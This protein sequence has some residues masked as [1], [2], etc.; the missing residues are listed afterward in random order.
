M[1]RLISAESLHANQLIGL[2]DTI[3]LTPD[4]NLIL[5]AL[6]FLDPKIEG[7]RA[8]ASLRG[9]YGHT[10][11]GGFIIKRKGTEHPIPIGSMG[12][13]M[14]RMLAMAIAIT[15][16]KNGIL[17]VDEIDTGLHYSV[18]AEMW[19]L[20][21]NAAKAFNVQVFATT[22]SYDCVKSLSAICVDSG[23]DGNNVT[24]QRIEPERSRSVPYTE[25]EIRV[26]A[27]RH[28]EMR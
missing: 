13:G 8:Q 11:R 3:A 22:H 15:Q 4:E 24:V 14:W 10:N 27:E 12:D 28:V 2:W 17:L 6:Q 19:R 20:I 21:L 26:A 7:I 1:T 9:Y 16:C 18:M 5:S 25:D 23:H